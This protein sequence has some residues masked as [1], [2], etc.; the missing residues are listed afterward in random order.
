VIHRRGVWPTV[1]LLVIAMAG[2]VTQIVRGGAAAP[3]SP[4]RAGATQPAPAATA[5]AVIRTLAAVQQ[6]FDAGDVRPLC[7]AGVLVDPT[8]IRTQDERSGGCRAELAALIRH[9]PPLRLTLRRLT[10][11][12]GTACVDAT[13]AQGRRVAVHLVRRETRWLLSLG[14]G[15][16]PWP[17]LAGRRAS[18]PAPGPR[19]C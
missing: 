1:V 15:R 9:E 8:V 6:A 3:A 17:A 4:A 5:R 16:D 12:R 18:T 13:T 2:A 10:L 7:G 19:T 14:D 11:G